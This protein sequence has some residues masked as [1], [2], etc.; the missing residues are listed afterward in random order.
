MIRASHRTLGLRALTTAVLLCGVV[1]QAMQRADSVPA[2]LYFTVDSAVLAAGLVLWRLVHLA[3][4][5]QV[6]G[7]LSGGAVLGVVLSTLVYSTVIAPNSPSGTWFNANDDGWARTATVLL[8]AVA[9]VLV[10]VEYFVTPPPHASRA[11]EAVLFV[12]WPFTYLVVVG[13]L[14]WTKAVT[15]PYPFLRPSEVGLVGVVGVI[16]GLTA[17]A[18][19]L[20]VALYAAT[21]LARRRRQVDE[22]QT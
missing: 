14:A 13:G 16:A 20:A 7:V 9:P 18:L 17:I 12:W 19:F 10:L 2:Y 15:M 22:I 6:S 4:A 5:S 3:R 21:R 1:C 11:R 8:H